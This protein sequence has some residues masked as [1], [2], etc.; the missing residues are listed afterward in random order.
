MPAI[1]LSTAGSPE[2]VTSGRPAA[3]IP[4]AWTDQDFCEAFE[5]LKIP[6]EIFRHREHIRLGWI[7]SCHFPEDQALARIVQGIRAFAKHHGHADKYHHTITVAWMRLVGHAVRSEPPAPDFRTFASTQAQ[8][9][10][11][12][13]LE[14]YYSK[15]RL[16]SNAARHNWLDPD[17]R[18]LPSGL[19]QIPS[20]P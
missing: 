2:K 6:N 19:Y 9:L 7:Y 11:P 5:S 8:L 3:A 10:N 16:Q 14:D 17:L 12:R 15:A 20:S 4:E 1:D 18:P 13:L